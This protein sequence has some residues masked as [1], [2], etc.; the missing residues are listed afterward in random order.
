MGT[1]TERCSVC[2]ADMEKL[3]G[4]E[5]ALCPKCSVEMASNTENKEEIGEETSLEIE[6]ILVL[7]QAAKNKNQNNVAYDHYVSIL[8]LNPNHVD[9]IYGKA[10]ILA[11]QCSL[12]NFNL[13]MVIQEFERVTTLI[14]K[15]T[16]AQMV[17]DI[18]K[19]LTYICYDMYN[20]VYKKFSAAISKDSYLDYVN[21]M[22]MVLKGFDLVVS[23]RPNDV[24]ILKKKLVITKAFAKKFESELYNDSYTLPTIILNSANQSISSMD[25]RIKQLQQAGTQKVD[26]SCYIATKVYGSYDAQQVRIL[27]DFRDNYLLKRKWGSV[28]VKI[29]YAFGPF[30]AK[31]IAKDSIVSSGVRKLLDTFITFYRK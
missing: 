28:F 31:R 3:E 23:L 15:E 2:S 21:K 27:R 29:Y 22:K 12:T 24:E 9:A 16:Q 18:A 5:V 30:M 7:A 26:G 4:Q 13:Q 25:A 8:E 11:R 1:D 14:V 17:N 19:E 6:E 10:C 20:S